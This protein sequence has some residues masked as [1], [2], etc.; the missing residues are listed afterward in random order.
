MINELEQEVRKYTDE[1]IKV[2]DFDIKSN[3][4]LM[5]V[6]GSGKTT[7]ACERVN[8][9]ISQ[10]VDPSE[11]LFFSYTKAAVEEFRR[12]LNNDKIKITTIHAFCQ[13]MLTKMGKY[14]NVISIYDFID[15]YKKKNKPLNTSSAKVKADYYEL[16]ADL[17]ENAEYVS[18]EIAAFKLQSANG[19]KSKVPDMFN[20]Y[21]KFAKETKSRDF[22]DMLIE[23]DTALKENKWLRMFRNQYK[24]ILVDE[25]QDTS[26]TQMNILLK[27]NAPYY[28]LIGDVNQS[29]YGY[30]GANAYEVM[31]LLK[32]RRSVQEMTLSVNF[33]SVKCIVDNSNSYS[34]LKASAFNDQKP[35][36]VS[37]R[38]IVF[39]KA[40]KILE[41]NEE[42]VFLCRTNKTIKEIERDFLRRKLNFN[43][44]NYLSLAEIDALKQS[45]AS[46]GT[47]K[48]VN[49]VLETFGTV[50]NL[51]TFIESKRDLKKFCMTIHKSKGLEFDTCIVVNCFAPDILELNNI[52]NLDKEQLKRISFD[53]TDETDYE[54]KNVFYVAITRP[55]VNLYY[56]AYNI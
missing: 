10:G 39:D 14:K 7:V 40:I 33:R 34:D 45:S 49:E 54:A 50:D 48:K 27:L 55:K 42:V 44:K 5:A 15:W 24:Y 11:I 8:F 1:Q 29:I 2:R 9:L 17:Y 43:Y 38:I 51:L 56:M 22:A 19:I 18:A 6:A 28:T 36:S 32:K 31:D 37:K 53:P 3:I 52:K 30:S 46:I 47:M 35:G 13:G 16:L 41:E 21:K 4:I 25:F 12:R 26:I 23:V 20:E